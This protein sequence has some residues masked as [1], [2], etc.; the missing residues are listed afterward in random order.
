MQELVLGGHRLLLLP[1][2]AV[3]IDH[4]RA[5]LVSDL[6]LGKAESFQ[7]Q[8]LPIPCQ[9]NQ[10]TLGRLQDLCE[11]YQPQ[12]LWVLGDLFHSAAAHQDG[13]TAEW[14]AFLERTGVRTQ[15]VLGNHDRPLASHL[16]QLPGICHPQSVVVDNLCLSHTPQINP[17]Q[18]TLCG[19][20]H[21]CLRLGGRG[22]RLRLPCF[23]WQPQGNCLTLPAFGEFTGGHPIN[24]AAGEVAYVVAEES[25]V[26]VTGPL[27]GKRQKGRKSGS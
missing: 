27:Q 22:D 13:M 7:R 11:A 23:H 17:D 26:P 6:H 19:H 16:R 5:L 24:L 20:I 25:L 3:Y 15:V 14:Q 10:V 18:P 21:P 9:V 8:G 1:Q 12:V 4:L 2:R